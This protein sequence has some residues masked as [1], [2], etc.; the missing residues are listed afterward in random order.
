MYFTERALTEK[1]L[2]QRGAE[3]VG[4]HGGR[5]QEGATGPQRQEGSEGG[6]R[7][8]TPGAPGVD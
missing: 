2:M 8:V 4:F 3:E 1:T 6:S 5:R 7:S